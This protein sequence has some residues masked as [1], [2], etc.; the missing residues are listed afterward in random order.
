MDKLFIYYKLKQFIL[1]EWENSVTNSIQVSSS[2]IAI[3]QSGPQTGHVGELS[4]SMSLL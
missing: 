2:L 3:I 4:K 1:E